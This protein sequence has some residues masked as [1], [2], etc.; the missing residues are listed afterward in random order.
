MNLAIKYYNE[1]LSEHRD[2]KVLEKV[3]KVSFS[4]FRIFSK[5]KIQIEKTK[6]KF[7]CIMQT[8]GRTRES[9]AHHHKLS[10]KRKPEAVESDLESPKVK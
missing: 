4:A 3:N 10:A 1:S 7:A 2:K 5:F 9:E 8:G 6:R